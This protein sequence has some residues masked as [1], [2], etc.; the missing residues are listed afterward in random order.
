MTDETSTKQ[1]EY[2]KCLQQRLKILMNHFEAGKLQIVEGSPAIESLK[3]IRHASNGSIDLDTVDESV[4]AMALA[5][6]LLSNPEKMK[7]STSLLEIQ[8]TYFEFL[9]KN[10]GQ[11]YKIMLDRGFTPHDAGEA[12]SSTPN[13]V[14]KLTKNLPEFLSAIEEFW[15]S[16]GPIA[17]AHVEDMHKSLKGVYGGDL[18][19]SV[20]EN[21]A[22][23]CGLYTDTIILPDPYL[24]SKHIFEHWTAEK[25]AYYLIKHALNLLQYKTLACN[26]ITPPIVVVIPDTSIFQKGDREFIYRLGQDDAVVHATRVFG[27]KFGSFDELK[28]FCGQLDTIEHAASEIKDQNRVLFDTEKEGT[29]SEQLEMATKNPIYSGLIK[30]T[31]PGLIMANQT[32]GRM[33]ISNE[34]L[35]KAQRLRG[36]PILDDP[37]SWQYFVW[38]LEYDASQTEEIEELK[39]LH[40]VRGLQTLAENKMQWLGKVP[41]KAL[42]EV[43]QKGALSEIR[44][45]LSKGVEELAMANPTNFHETSELVFKNIHTAFIEHQ[46]NVKAL[47]AKKWKFAGSELGS[48]MVVG[49]LMVTAAATEPLI[50]KIAALA[51]KEL[52]PAPKLRDIP[53]SIKDLTTE[54][55]KLK[56]SPVGILFKMSKS[57]A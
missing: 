28:E 18:F 47:V 35:I 8:K 52:L 33:C 55:N 46:K 3:Q 36:I 24:R 19:P 53:Q 22:S 56:R 32:L 20:D 14:N 29:V 51:A 9:E 34:L 45:I 54:N 5:V 12:L 25:K 48:W 1:H 44:S 43:R 15:S 50:W 4:R 23:K 38:K 31:S 16:A 57:G 7:D 42:L 10:F 30:T 40:V 41:L 11:Y 39:D 26:D 37:T 49:S 13:T 6:E 21:I 2:E 17:I 27:R